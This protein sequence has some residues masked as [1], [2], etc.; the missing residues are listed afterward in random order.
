MRLSSSIDNLY[1]K[2]QIQHLLGSENPEKNHHK[3]PA[4]R[5]K[6]LSRKTA[7]QEGVGVRLQTSSLRKGQQPVLK[8][9]N[10][11]ETAP[12]SHPIIKSYTEKRLGTVQGDSLTLSLPGSS[13]VWWFGQV[14]GQSI[15]RA[16]N[17]CGVHLCEGSGDCSLASGN[18]E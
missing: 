3:R 17:I 8:G 10:H 4:L 9:E 7:I 2:N 12:E 16:W 13:V 5:A 1:F 18:C 14:L 6:N 11:K 15:R